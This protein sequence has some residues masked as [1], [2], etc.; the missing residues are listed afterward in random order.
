M[1]TLKQMDP[2]TMDPDLLNSHLPKGIW[3]DVEKSKFRVR[4]YRNRRPL[5][6]GYHDT[7]EE[8][9]AAFEKLKKFREQIPG[10]RV[11]R[12]APRSLAFADTCKALLNTHK[13]RK[14]ILRV[15]D[16]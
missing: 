1:T 14:I 12:K 8:A 6:G 4:L 2:T 5:Q 15:P 10:D 9:L 11:S 16:A 3:W 7:L 13:T